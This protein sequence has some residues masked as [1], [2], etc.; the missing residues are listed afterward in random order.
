M[1]PYEVLG[2]KEH[3]SIDEISRVFRRLAKKYHPDIAVNDLEK[4]VMRE[5]FMA[6]TKA[7][8]EIKAMKHRGDYSQVHSRKR[9]SENYGYAIINKAKRFIMNKDY[10]SAIKILKGINT[11][12]DKLYLE[13]SMLLGEAYF[14]KERYHEALKHFKVVYDNRPW[15]IDIK[16]KMAHVYENV[17]LK[18]TAKKIYEEVLSFDS[19]NSKAL[20]GISRIN[21]KKQFSL[22][23]L[24]K[25]G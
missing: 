14:R 6:I 20:E 15:D 11:A 19:G 25:K 3:D 1:N 2:V 22:S 17:G 9:Q 13:V 12:N 16:L 24:F 21:A 5:K 18:N 4:A 8:N 7:Y 23:E 10:N